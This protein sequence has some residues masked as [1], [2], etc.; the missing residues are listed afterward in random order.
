MTKIFPLDFDYKFFL[1]SPELF[2]EKYANDENILE[3][4]LIVDQVKL[5]SSNLLTSNQIYFFY[6]NQN[7][8]SSK[9][10]DLLDRITSFEHFQSLL[11]HLIRNS[12]IKQRIRLI[13]SVLQQTRFQNEEKWKIFEDQNKRTFKSFK[14]L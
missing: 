12:S 5:S 4:G 1:S 11:Q 8:T 9:I 10:F 7:P 14:N 13:I 3:F 2:V 6:L